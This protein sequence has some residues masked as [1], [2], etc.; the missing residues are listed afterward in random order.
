[1]PKYLVIHPTRNREL[2]KIIPVGTIFEAKFT[3]H[4]LHFKH[5][6]RLFSLSP[7]MIGEWYKEIDAKETCA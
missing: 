4:S 5:G 2:N 6:T 7:K 3:K 1:M